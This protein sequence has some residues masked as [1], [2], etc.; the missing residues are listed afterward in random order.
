MSNIR[1][2]ISLTL[3]PGLGSVGYW[4][5]L[6]QF[7]TPTAVLE[8]DLAALRQRAQLREHQLKGFKDIDRLRESAERELQR[9]HGLGAAVVTADDPD[10]PVM[11][12]E[13][14]NPPP[15]LFVKGNRKCL[16]NPAVAI[17]G[18]RAATRY[19]RRAAFTLAKE[20]A[21]NGI[22]IVSGLAAGIDGEA[23]AGA[24]DGGGETIGV[25]GCGLDVI[26][27]RLNRT[28]YHQVEGQGARVSEYGLG[29]KPDGFRFP[30][31]NRIIAGMCYGVVVVEAAKKS[32]SLITVQHALDEGR[33]VLAVP[34][35]IDSVKSSGTHWLLQQGATLAASADDVLA[36]LPIDTLSSNRVEKT[37]PAPPVLEGDTAL[38]LAAIEHYPIQKD[39]LIEQTGFSPARMSEQLLLL[40]L[41][42]LIEI[43]PGDKVRR[44]EK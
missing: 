31:R 29:T 16:N 38:L 32:G 11:L 18:S 3:V 24:L 37:K 12:K 23:H 28:L 36:A 15:I 22:T 26:Y 5:L 25:L 4:K 35:Q 44:I 9:L 42:G 41:D 34:G 14:A 20:L 30:A 8:S 33:D 2:W 17:V 7:G 40:E 1:D 13:C 21:R 19:G 27:P 43:L 6:D 10:Y 39:E